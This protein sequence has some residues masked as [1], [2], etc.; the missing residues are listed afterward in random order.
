M[1]GQVVVGPPGSGKSTYCAAVVEFLRGLGRNVC[2]VNLDPANERCAYE[3][4]LDIRDLVQLDAVA[5]EHALGP[6]GALIY[7]MEVLEKNVDWLIDHLVELSR[8]HDACRY[9]LLDLPG[10]AEL[11]THHHALKHVLDELVYQP[12]LRMRLCT[13]NLVD[14]HYCL[15]SSRF[16]SV[17][18]HSWCTM[19][20][21]EQPHVNLVTKMDLADQFEGMNIRTEAFSAD[22]EYVLD[23]DH[24]VEQL[25][26][27]HKA[28]RFAS[29]NAA[30]L[31]AVDDYAQVWFY[32]LNLS[33][34]DCMLHAQMKIDQ[35]MGYVFREQDA[36]RAAA[37]AQARAQTNE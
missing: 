23:T 1:F 12:K 32:T 37:Q 24:L 4:D 35:A 20:H 8:T 36:L 6:N 16:V 33:D 9:F 31:E 26:Q 11:F 18:L 25:D 28:G 29:L 17:L 15:D 5:S 13:V 7:C 22:S 19:L 30:L 34:R 21:L 3:P 27:G 14:V 10:Q 2:V